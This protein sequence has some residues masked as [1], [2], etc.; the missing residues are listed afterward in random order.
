MLILDIFYKYVNLLYFYLIFHRL[1]SKNLLHKYLINWGI[2]M[3]SGVCQN[4]S[5]NRSGIG[6]VVPPNA[7]ALSF[8]FGNEL[9]EGF[10]QHPD[11]FPLQF[12]RLRFWER[13]KLELTQVSNIGLTF[14]SEHYQKPGSL[15]EI[16]IP[17]RKETH[18]F[19]GKVVVV[20]ES[21]NSYEIGIWLMNAEDAP[22]LRIIEQICHIELY[23]NDKK[24]K[25]GPFLSKEKL[26]EEWISRFASSFPVS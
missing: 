20:K 12:R 6:S 9:L 2:I 13:A 18:R 15:L 10:I 8:N 4:R 26:T 11:R 14:S 17:T 22:K 7:A 24:Y 19:L 5:S 25:D 16:T 1:C 21:V 23:L 3:M